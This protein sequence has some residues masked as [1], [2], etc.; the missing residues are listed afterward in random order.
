[1]RFDD[2]KSAALSAQGKDVQRN[3]VSILLVTSRSWGLLL[4]MHEFRRL[5][6]LSLLRQPQP[7]RSSPR[8]SRS[9]NHG[10][11]WAW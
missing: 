3:L 5:A 10:L 4:A 6:P 7:L 11:R 8:V 2:V 1:M 9:P